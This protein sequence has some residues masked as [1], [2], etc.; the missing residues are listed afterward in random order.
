MLMNIIKLVLILSIS[1]IVLISS[2]NAI[3]NKG[4]YLSTVVWKK[5]NISV[6][7]EDFDDIS[8]TP[9]KRNLVK[10]SIQSTWESVSNLQFT[11]W[12][13]CTIDGADIRIR[14]E[15]NGGAPHTKGLGTRLQNKLNGMSLN[16]SFNSWGSSCAS[17]EEQ[18]NMC[19]KTIA[20]HEFGHALGI[21]HEQNRPDTPET[22]RQNP[23]GTYGDTE[24][25]DWDLM[26]V[27]NYCNPVWNNHG[28][29]S[30]T[31]IKTIQTMYN[32]NYKYSPP[33][34]LLHNF[35]YVSGWRVD[36]HPR[37]L[38]DVNGDGRADIVGFWNNGVYVALS[39]GNGFTQAS[40]WSNDFGYVSGGWRVDQH[41]RML[42]DVNGDGRADIVGFASR[43]VFVALSTG[44]GFTQASKW[45]NDFGYVSGGW[46]VDQHPRMLTDVNGD[47][48]ADIVGF[49]SYGVYVSTY[50]Y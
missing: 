5:P 8:S 28:N 22:C 13:E 21:A 38:T 32:I 3:D 40:K 26:S 17:S 20:I 50:I 44:D 37:I 14:V 2:D 6:C 1:S 45:S 43:G 34:N 10:K 16:F 12:N 30:S 41:P 23:Q 15:D 19:I 4:Y 27:M 7:W 46:R 31:D 33:K 9:A 35:N 39:T 29:L 24:V 11:G 47:G 18:V 36:Q 42:T 49:G 48:R 25:G